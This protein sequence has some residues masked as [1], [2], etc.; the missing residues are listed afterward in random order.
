MAVSAAVGILL[1]VKRRFVFH[2]C[3]FGYETALEGRYTSNIG[4]RSVYEYL[5]DFCIRDNHEMR[6]AG[7]PSLPD[8]ITTLGIIKLLPSYF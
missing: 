8:A 6:R 3:V 2:V 4:N 7:V 5:D 1:K